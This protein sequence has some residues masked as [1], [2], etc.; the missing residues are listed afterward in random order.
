MYSPD[1]SLAKLL[2]EKG[3]SKYSTDS[4]ELFVTVCPDVSLAKLLTE[5]G[6]S[7]Y[8]TDSNELFVI[9]CPDV[10]LAKLLTEKGESKYST[11]SNK[12][13][14]TVCQV[15]GGVCLRA[16]VCVHACIVHTC[17]LQ[18]F[19]QFLF[20]SLGTHVYVGSACVS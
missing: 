4:N 3:E 9:V 17:E 5:K 6:E 20:T 7:K 11:D 10:S 2:T 8:S 15:V 13:F 18:N 1:V 14:V 19:K 12:L 16:C